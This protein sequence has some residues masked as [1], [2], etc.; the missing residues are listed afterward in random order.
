MN[1]ELYNKLSRVR[2][3]LRDKYAKVGKAPLICHDEE[4]ISMAELKPRTKEE[5][6]YINGLGQVFMEKYGDDFIKVIN[7]YYDNLNTHEEIDSDI[8]DTLKNYEKRLININKRNRLLYS[9]KLY[10]NSSYDL[11]SDK[12]EKFNHD[13]VRLIHNRL[14]SIEL[15]N[16]SSIE[17]VEKYKR[18]STL[19]REVNAVYREKGDFDLYIGYPFVE[20]Y[21]EEDDFRVRAPLALFP[22]IVTKTPT[23][24]SLSIDYS[25]DILYNNVFILLYN[26]YHNIYDELPL[27]VVEETFNDFIEESLLHYLDVGIRI[28][29]DDSNVKI[30]KYLEYTK[31]TFPKYRFDEFKLVPNMVL[32]RYSIFSSAIQKDYKTLIN[33]SDLPSLLFNLLSEG[34]QIKKTIDFKQIKEKEINY[35]TDLDGSQE[36][37]IYQMNALDS[38][39]IEGPPGT[40]KSQTITSLIIDTVAKNKTILMVSEKKAALEVIYSRLGDISK[41]AMLLSDVNDKETFYKQL[42]NLFMPVSLNNVASKENV[43]RLADQIDLDLD[44]LEQIKNILFENKINNVSPIIIY[45]EN[46]NNSVKELNSLQNYV[47]LIDPK[48]LNMD[49]E[50]L[51]KAHKLFT[52]SSLFNDCLNVEGI[53]GKY[54][55]LDAIKELS[56][57]ENNRMIQDIN[58]FYFNHSNYLKHG[59]LIKLFTHSR[60]KRNFKN[61]Y[62]TYFSNHT[63]YKYLYHHF[64]ELK[65]SISKLSLYRDSLLSYNT[66]NDCEKLYIQTIYKLFL[67]NLNIS[68]DLLFD[69]IVNNIMEKFSYENHDIVKII[70]DYPEIVF[71][72]VNLIDQKK[73]ET[74]EMTKENLH[75][76]Y[77]SII[78]DSKRYNDLRR[79]IESKRKSSIGRFINKFRFELFN[80]IR[81][82]LMTPE[83]VS[84]LLPLTENSFDLLIFD[85]ASQIYIE[86]SLPAIYRANKVV[87]SGDTKQ[88]NPSSLGFARFDDG[89]DDN[90]Y[91]EKT[92]LEEKSLLDLAKYRYPEVLLNYHYR[93]KYE[94]LINFSNAAYYDFKLNVSPNITKPATPPIEVIKV[95]GG[96]FIKRQN[97]VEALRAINLLKDILKNRQNNETV[98]IIT[99]NSN[100]RDLI[101][102]LIDEESIIDK[103][104]DAL[105]KNEFNR[106]DNGEDTG[107]FV[108]NIENVQGDE[109]DIIIFVVGY[110]K[111]ENGSIS[112]NFGWLNQLGGENRL[113]V[114]VSRAKQKIYVI[115]SITPNELDVTNAKNVGPKLFKKYLE[116]AYLV[117]NQD[118]NNTKILLESLSNNESDEVSSS[119]GAFENEVYN[120]L[121]DYIDSE[122]FAID[123]EVGNSKYRISLGIKDRMTNRYIL[124]IECDNVISNNLLS[125]KE[126]DIFRYKYLKSRSWEIIRI[127]SINWYKSPIDETNKIVNKLNE[128]VQKHI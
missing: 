25:K 91:L 125:T 128:L 79:A 1:I 76:Q 43:Q 38:L 123:R 101:Y 4:L 6:I 66:L 33:S 77:V 92:N 105:C 110:A 111:G 37:A 15:C 124:G 109:R 8:R 40:G 115:T 117:S 16:T 32:G 45:Q 69:I 94:E 98:G 99:F 53:K 27:D 18:L 34:K 90:E 57:E 36:K 104:F 11:F 89:I 13:I 78:E 116:Y 30:S 35:I 67:A 48:L 102:D 28:K 62:R 103:D 5:L 121:C 80:G 82:W 26:K 108:K 112:T 23:K 61:L 113:N 63:Y 74:A 96:T 51:K 120:Y 119:Y 19:I 118:V 41:Y 44:K 85:E 2:Q 68:N 122:R 24:V 17:G 81:I 107:L 29:L 87:I 75:T 97:K 50:E 72:I 71:E 39:V 59:P 52:K 14:D 58:E 73:K 86:K 84:E 88:L 65:I 64:D 10:Q 106:I 46:I 12:N 127:W 126:R 100:E 9:G 20:G 114:A 95:E 55:W 21:F 60:E 56:Y 22:V 49:Y 83:I 7:D 42:N 93:S 54:P 47:A 3:Q 31:D 70:S